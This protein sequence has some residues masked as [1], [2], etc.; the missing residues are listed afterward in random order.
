MDW[1]SFRK[2]LHL[3]AWTIRARGLRDLHTR[4]MSDSSDC[5]FC[6]STTGTALVEARPTVTK[7]KLSKKI[8]DS[9]RVSTEGGQNPETFDRFGHSRYTLTG[10]TWQDSEKELQ[11]C[12]TG[13]RPNFSGPCL[14]W[15][16][17]PCRARNAMIMP[18]PALRF[19]PSPMIL[20]QEALRAERTSAEVAFGLYDRISAAIAAACG[21]A[22][23]VP[24]N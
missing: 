24:E 16:Y 18:S 2:E 3:A 19:H 17:N 22:A 23:D 1:P 21:A 6:P 15:R 4:A 5:C 8:A 20:M 12:L 11:K 14:G 9:R 7:A 10:A 13:S